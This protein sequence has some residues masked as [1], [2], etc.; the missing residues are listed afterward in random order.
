MSRSLNFYH[1]PDRSLLQ[2]S[3]KDAWTLGDAYEGVHIFGG[4][5]S[6]KTSASGRAL[7]H[8]YL[9]SG[10]GGLVLTAKVD[11]ADLW[12]RYAKETGRSKSLIRFGPESGLTF[13]FLDYELY[14]DGPEKADTFEALDV[15]MRTVEAIKIEQNTGGGGSDDATW[16]GYA[17]T[18]IGN[19]IDALFAAYG[20]VRPHDILAMATSCPNTPAEMRDPAF[21]D[22]SFC[23]R[24]LRKAYADPVHPMAEST[25]T[26][27]Q[28][29]WRD[30]FARLNDRTRSSIVQVAD[31][32]LSPFTSGLLH[33]VFCQDT[34]IVPELTHEGAI[35]VLDFPVEQYNLRGLIAQHIFKYVWQRA[36]KRRPAQPE[37]RPVFLWADESQ[38][39]VS[40]Y[41]AHFQSTA[42]S[43]R[44]CSVY[45]SQNINHYYRVMASRDPRG[46]TG[47]L[48]GNFRTQI[49]HTNQDTETNQY[50]VGM[51]GRALMARE[52]LGQS[53]ERGRN[54]G[55]SDQSEYVD[56][57]NLI[58]MRS[59][60]HGSSNV[61]DSW[62][63]S[64]SHGQ[65]QTTSY[66]M[67][68][69]VEPNF[70]VSGLRSGGKRNQRKVDGLIVHSGR[71]FRSNRD[72]PFIVASFE[73]PRRR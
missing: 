69:K 26:K 67:D 15:L 48:L 4:T 66:S 13:N 17:K 8:A 37:R 7:A 25:A 24:T 52:S 36:V 65:S 41:D 9:K 33:D 29:Y 72:Q 14:R 35:I 3:G 10:M 45:I 56:N 44:A 6:G 38:F 62:G 64:A 58:G 1:D 22:R 21:L 11:E 39:F 73:Q 43:A 49:F 28:R 54:T 31:S 47:S 19:A 12:E 16:I 20:S 30:N 40:Q 18:L 57:W 42:R 71:T 63:D 51:I 70:F 55:G 60:A 50:A 46:A 27:V 53:S 59:G 68:L 2:F 61:S 32:I 5:G 34:K 23:Y